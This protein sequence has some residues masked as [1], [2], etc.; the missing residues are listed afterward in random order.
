[1]PNPFVAQDDLE[2]GL[3]LDIRRIVKG[4]ANWEGRDGFEF[5]I[6]KETSLGE[7]ERTYRVKVTPQIADDIALYLTK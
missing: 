2:R 5:C 7:N 4:T 6:G 1:M 3:V